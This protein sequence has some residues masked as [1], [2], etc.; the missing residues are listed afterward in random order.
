[1]S[2]SSAGGGLAAA[3][4]LK[5]APPNVVLVDGTNHHLFQR[6]LYQAATSV[7]AAGQVCSP[8]RGIVGKQRN[9]TVILGEVVMASRLLHSR[10]LPIHK[11]TPGTGG[12]PAPISEREI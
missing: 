3:K 8:I 6:L 12:V 2:L 9:T 10:L 5:N 4:A 11:A 1:V 7:L